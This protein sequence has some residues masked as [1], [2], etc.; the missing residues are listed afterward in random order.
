M[1][2]GIRNTQRNDIQRLLNPTRIH[3]LH[4][5]V[6]PFI[7]QK[8]IVIDPFHHDRIFKSTKK[9]KCRQISSVFSCIIWSGVGQPNLVPTG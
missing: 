5:K 2:I 4:D 1:G 9:L 3:K 7:G 6:Q 8:T